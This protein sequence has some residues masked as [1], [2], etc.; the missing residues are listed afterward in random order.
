ML[1]KNR[2]TSNGKASVE[3]P[4]PD[5]LQVNFILIWLI[6]DLTLSKVESDT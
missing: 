4:Y 1:L 3:C 5:I 6:V 2:I